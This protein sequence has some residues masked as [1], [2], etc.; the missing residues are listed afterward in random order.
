MKILSDWSLGNPPM[1]GLWL[2]RLREQSPFDCGAIRRWTGDHWAWWD[3]GWWMS[4]DP[5][6]LQ[7]RGLTFD[8]SAAHMYCEDDGGDYWSVK[9]P[10]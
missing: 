1:P 10:R 3:G 8:P 2:V 7:W 5:N 9:V 6:R 4:A